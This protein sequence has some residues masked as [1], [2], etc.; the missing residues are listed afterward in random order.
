MGI[1]RTKI[2]ATI[3]PASYTQDALFDLLAAGCDLIRINFSHTEHVLVAELVKLVRAWSSAN[4]KHIG[5]M[6]DLAGP[7]IRIG[8]VIN[9]QVSLQ[10]GQQIIID[11]NFT[12]LGDEHKIGINYPKILTDVTVND[13]LLLDD[14]KIQLVVH[15]LMQHQLVCTVSHAGDLGSYKGVNKFGGG[16]SAGCLTAKDELD[17]KFAATIGVDYVAVSFVRTSQD[18]AI[19]KKI[20]DN[21]HVSAKLIAKIER[22]EAL[23]NL[24]DIINNA[25]GVMVARGDL[26]IEVGVEQL[27]SLQKLIIS[28]ARALNKAVITATQMMESMVTNTTPT[29]AE[30]SDIA[31]AVFDGSDAIMFSAETAV[32][33]HPAL[34]VQTAIAICQSAE[35]NPL[36]FSS[37]HRINNYFTKSEESIAMAAMYIA[38]HQDIKAV[39]AI[40]TTGTTPLWMS[41]I[42]SQT[43]IY[44]FSVHEQT[45]CWLS[46]YRDV[47]PIAFTST[48]A[49][50]VSLQQLAITKLQDDG[51]LQPGDQVIITYGDLLNNADNTNALVI[52]T[53]TS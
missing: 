12:G 2:I 38:N 47:Y 1:K 42:R 6:A 15:E 20:L 14:G 28:K 19:V 32:G 8:K 22:K 7:K 51:M 4:N 50:V 40:T 41:R 33:A 18:L 44:A 49:E 43:P 35:S 46:L 9:D 24:S 36:T 45:L 27:P 48:N 37:K 16:L 30:V 3:G 31:N 17:L 13:R 11:P 52:K 23:D 34:V 21:Y 39:I 26:G 29:R 25:D 5:I 53:V 10:A